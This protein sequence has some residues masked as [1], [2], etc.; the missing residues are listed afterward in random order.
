M[1]NTDN[2]IFYQNV[3]ISTG[4]SSLLTNAIGL[5]SNGWQVGVNIPVYSSK[6]F[7]WDVNT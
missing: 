1:R 5:S 4:A 7:Q 3:P 6:N 2:A